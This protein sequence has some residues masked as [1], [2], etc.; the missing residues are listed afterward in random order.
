MIK[1]HSINLSPDLESQ[2][3]AA[4]AVLCCFQQQ[5]ANNCKEKL[6]QHID[7]WAARVIVQQQQQTNRC[8]GKL[9][10]HMVLWEAQE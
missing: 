5:E 9:Q 10:Q 8:K 6:Q 3:R 1:I 4:V 7:L 2:L